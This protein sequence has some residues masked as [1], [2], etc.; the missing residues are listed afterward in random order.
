M[1]FQ[2]ALVWSPSGHGCRAWN[3]SSVV[4]KQRATGCTLAGVSAQVSMELDWT[5]TNPSTPRSTFAPLFVDGL[6][7]PRGRDN[8]MIVPTWLTAMNPR[9][10]S[11]RRINSAAIRR[12]MPS[13][14]GWEAAGV[15]VKK[16]DRSQ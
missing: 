8:Q 11:A 14:T 2:L 12:L 9:V 16:I 4:G 3:R 7:V 10:H 6:D 5:G 1:G 13:M 15:I